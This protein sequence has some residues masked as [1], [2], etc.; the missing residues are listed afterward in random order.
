MEQLTLTQ[1]SET[2]RIVTVSRTQTS[3]LGQ[4]KSDHSSLMDEGGEA[5]Q[6]YSS[7]NLLDGSPLRINEIHVE[8]RTM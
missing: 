3:N 1:E 6:W 2:G 7:T 8:R 5:D 4:V